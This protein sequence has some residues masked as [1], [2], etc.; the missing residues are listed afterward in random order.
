MQVFAAAVGTLAAII[1][2]L[3]TSVSLPDNS[4][5]ALVDHVFSIGEVAVTTKKTVAVE[6]E[7]G[8]GTT[9]IPI[10]VDTVPTTPEPV[11]VTVQKGDSLSKIAAANQ[12]TVQRLFDANSSIADPN[13]INPGDQIRIPTADEQLESRAMPVAAPKPIAKSKAPAIKRTNTGAVA[14]AVTD[15]SVWDALARCESGGNWAINTGNGYYGGLQFNTGTWLGNGGGAYAPRADLAT[16]E[17]QIDIASRVA[18][19]RGFKPWP[20]CARKLGLL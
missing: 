1:T 6:P 19:A 13:V 4:Q 15:G 5:L 12:T 20:A 8:T 11:V 17:Q 9:E 7:A 10:E 3:G 16:R 2:G 14:P 18:A